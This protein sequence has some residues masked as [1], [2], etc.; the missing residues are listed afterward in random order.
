MNDIEHGEDPY[1]QQLERIMILL[2]SE[3]GARLLVDRVFFS[4][5]GMSASV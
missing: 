4:N 1:K 3:H 5:P 2:E